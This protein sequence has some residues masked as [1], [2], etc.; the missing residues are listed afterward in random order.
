MSP[1]NNHVADALRA[2]GIATLLLDLLTP[3]EEGRRSNVFNIPL[4]AGRLSLATASARDLPETA[5]LPVGYFGASTGAGAALMAAADDERIGAVVSRG[6]RPDLA[7]DALQRVRAPTLLIVGE[8][9]EVVLELNRRARARLKTESELV[10]VPG[11]THL[12]GEPG[13]L[14]EVVRHAARW[15]LAHL[16]GGGDRFG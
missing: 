1:R 13:A 2:S 6:G 8:R 14:D 3:E 4:L 7:N 12:F 5:S 9:D 15:F 10:V 11:A 16:P